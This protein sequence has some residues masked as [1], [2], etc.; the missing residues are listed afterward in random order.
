MLYDQIFELMY[1]GKLGFTF[2]EL[3]NLPVFLRT[4]YYKK[5]LDVKKKEVESEQAEVSKIKG[6]MSKR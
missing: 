1:Y 5:L 4:Y 3:Y 2:S 6:S